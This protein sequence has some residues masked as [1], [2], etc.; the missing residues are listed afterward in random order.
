MCV[1]EEEEFQGEKKKET[2]K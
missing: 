2:W 1:Y